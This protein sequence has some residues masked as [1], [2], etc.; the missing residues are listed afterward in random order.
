MKL[1]RINKSAN[2]TASQV[3]KQHSYPLLNL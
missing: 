2:Y 1:I 3:F